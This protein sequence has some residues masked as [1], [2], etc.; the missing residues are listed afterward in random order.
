MAPDS[1]TKSLSTSFT[2]TVS[3]TQAA[4]V[5]NPMVPAAS[6]PPL[7]RTQGRGTQSSGT[8]KN[9]RDRRVGHPPS[10][11]TVAATGMD[12]I[13]HAGCATV[14]RQNAGQMTPLPPGI[15]F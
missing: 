12:V 1:E 4:G 3:A 14:A 8:G 15:T 2:R 9:E 6:Y 13:A 11:E 10:F 7:Q 5:A